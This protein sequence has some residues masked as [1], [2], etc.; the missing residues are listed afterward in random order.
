M[1]LTRAFGMVLSLFLVRGCGG[2]GNGGTG[3]G[4]GGGQGGGGSGGGGGDL[5][6][7]DGGRPR[8]FGKSNS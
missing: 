7:G 5:D 8:S 4:G 2:G 6:G 1:L 3:G